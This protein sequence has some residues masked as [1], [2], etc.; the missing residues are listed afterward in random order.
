MSWKPFEKE[1]EDLAQNVDTDHCSLWRILNLAD[2]PGMHWQFDT[3]FPAPL[4]DI[5]IFFII[6]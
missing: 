2:C 3:L 1:T 5:A 4:T 6:T